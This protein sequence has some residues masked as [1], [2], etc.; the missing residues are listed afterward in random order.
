M[1]VSRKRRAALAILVFALLAPVAAAGQE[2]D[3]LGDRKI[4]P[5]ERIGRVWL[6]TTVGE[7]TRVIGPYNQR[8]AGDSMFFGT[9]YYGW[10]KFG[11]AVVADDLTRRALW[12][13]VSKGGSTVW[14]TATTADGLGFGATEPELVS[15]LGSPSR[16]YSDSNGRSVY[17]D[18]KGVR[19]FLAT[20]G[21]DAGRAVAVRV[22]WPH[23]V[24]G[25]G[26]IVP[27]ERIGSVKVGMPI[28]EVR[29][30]LGGGH[31]QASGL[32]VWLH[33]GVFVKID[34][35]LRVSGI[36]AFSS[37]FLAG[38]GVKYALE[39]GLTIGSSEAQITEAFGR[40][41]IRGKKEDA[42]GYFSRG[43]GFVLNAEGQVRQIQ[44]FA[45]K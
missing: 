32:Y 42:L 12:V 35:Q 30:A 22:V 33:R 44:V 16:Q 26:V 9:T 37:S 45:K 6:G 25:D 19:F 41:S 27:G 23:V 13:S 21:P 43:I 14:W 17:F 3:L 20:S 34:H 2:P 24:A 36:A 4:V 10:D 7:L 29:D 28:S 11:L 39:N 18:A 5:G 31:V 8:D 1:R 15:A 38:A 40:T